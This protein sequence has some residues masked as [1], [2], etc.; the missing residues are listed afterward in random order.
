MAAA[1]WAVEVC[2]CAPDA[3]LGE[4]ASGVFWLEP[5]ACAARARPRHH[6]VLVGGAAASEWHAAASRWQW[7]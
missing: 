7:R 2:A 3:L 5:A 4:G 1:G 6:A